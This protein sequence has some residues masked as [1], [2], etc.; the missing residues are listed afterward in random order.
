MKISFVIGLLAASMLCAPA[1]AQE[2][3]A[4]TG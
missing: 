2:D 1:L 3:T 4:V